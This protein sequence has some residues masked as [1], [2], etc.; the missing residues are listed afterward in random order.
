[1]FLY[2]YI[3]YSL[4]TF[5]Y[6]SNAYFFFFFFSFRS[7][8]N[9]E[10]LNSI[11]NIDFINSWEIQVSLTAFRESCDI[12]FM[13]STTS[14][15]CVRLIIV[16]LCAEN[17]GGGDLR[18]FDV[19]FSPFSSKWQWKGGSEMGLRLRR[20]KVIGYPGEVHHKKMLCS[21]SY[22][23]RNDWMCLLPRLDFL[24]FFL[25]MRL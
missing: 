1:M 7:R 13:K 2:V 19:A 21:S 17:H 22:L 24:N 5:L 10:H 15:S 9:P 6:S 11:W 8:S 20:Y 16:Q 12:W 14:S 23:L 3:W 18:P 25:W 4:I